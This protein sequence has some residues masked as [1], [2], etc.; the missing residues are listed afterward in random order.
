MED[1]IDLERLCIPLEKTVSVSPGPINAGILSKLE[2]SGFDQAPVYDQNTKTYFGLIET[3]YLRS[4]FESGDPVRTEDPIVN[5]GERE[6]H[7][8]SFVT[9]FDLLGKMT[10]QR[11][12]V[13]IH[14][15]DVTE[16]GPAR[17]IF[18][19]FTI[20]DLNRH[21]VRSAIYHLL[22]DVEAG[23][24]KWLETIVTDPWEW[25]QQ[26]EEEQQARVLGYWELSKRVGIDVGPYA[27]LTLSQVVNIISR[28]GETAR[29]L[30]Y[31][32]RSQFDK[33]KSPLP[34]LRNR[35]MHPVRPLVLTEKDVASLNAAALILE[36]LRDRVESRLKEQRTT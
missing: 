25:L 17:F 14:D 28:N 15:S 29:R 23:L 1:I 9:I 24:V 33:A 36:D 32:S 16:H 3:T 12:I 35:V 13:V 4:L 30:G 18:G 2:G 34:N 22:A 20:S 26:L 8:G 7:V 5:N 6:F 21:A 27:A 11:A 19:L 10:T 31:E